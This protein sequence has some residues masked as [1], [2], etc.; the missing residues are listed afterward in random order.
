MGQT[1]AR[2][3]ASVLNEGINTLDVSGGDTTVTV[4]ISWTVEGFTGSG[5][6]WNDPN[7]LL[8]NGWREM[9][10]NEAT[11]KT[12]ISGVPYSS[13]EQGLRDY[14]SQ[15]NITN[16]DDVFAMW[17]SDESKSDFMIAH[18]GVDISRSCFN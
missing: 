3:S 11:R 18:L 4:A 1:Y 16:L 17:N 13:D 15:N 14:I 9:Q 6:F 8:D 2:V 12:N 7:N 10:G 5:W